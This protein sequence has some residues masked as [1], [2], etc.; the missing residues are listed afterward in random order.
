MPVTICT[1]S[2]TPIAAESQRRPRKAGGTRTLARAW[3]TQAVT[4][5]RA[6]KSERRAR[7]TRR[8]FV[9]DGAHESRSRFT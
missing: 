9:T 5:E 1:R 4:C 8:S 7:R 3:R 6:P 2:R